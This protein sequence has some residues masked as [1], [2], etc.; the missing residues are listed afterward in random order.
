MS[1]IRP[2]LPPIEEI[3]LPPAD[4]VPRGVMKDT[5]KTTFVVE[6]NPKTVRD[7]IDSD[8]DAISRN[9]LQ[10]N[11]GLIH[12]TTVKSP[13]NLPMRGS[14]DVALAPIPAIK[15]SGKPNL[16]ETEMLDNIVYEI[17][18]ESESHLME[19]AVKIVDKLTEEQAR[20]VEDEVFAKLYRKYDELAV[21]AINRTL[22]NLST[23]WN[24]G[25]DC[26]EVRKRLLGR[27]LNTKRGKVY[28]KNVEL[29]CLKDQRKVDA[30]LFWNAHAVQLY[31]F[32]ESFRSRFPMARA[33][34][35][36]E[37]QKNRDTYA[38][39]IET[40]PGALTGALE[41]KYVSSTDILN[42]D[43]YEEKAEKCYTQLLM[44]NEQLV[45]NSVRRFKNAQLASITSKVHSAI[46][47]TLD[48][49]VHEI[50]GNRL[51][52]YSKE[53]LIEM[54]IK[55]REILNDYRQDLLAVEINDIAI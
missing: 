48:D 9:S 47:R 21:K 49:A 36:A 13:S 51:E 3:N 40:Y 46:S 50:T 26:L 33:D 25:Y 16:S 5:G 55:L 54:K 4:H 17:L 20:V 12:A 31:T 18:T 38:K 7:A 8:R 14:P 52:C 41:F 22:P 44:N 37:I 39:S 42:D 24:E 15:V 53:E 35:K 2:N 23:A 19:E 10:D 11:P 6:E 30:E 1:S 28:K 27:G 34:L 32:A 43:S 45:E 29:M